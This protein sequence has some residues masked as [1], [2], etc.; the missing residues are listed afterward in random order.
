MIKNSDSFNW[1]LDRCSSF[2]DVVNVVRVH[3]DTSKPLTVT[4]KIVLKSG[5]KKVLSLLNLK[6]R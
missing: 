6:L 2:D 3:Y 4:Q 5:I 1:D